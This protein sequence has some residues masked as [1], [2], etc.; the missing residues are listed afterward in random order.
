MYPVWLKINTSKYI[1]STRFQKTIKQNNTM[2]SKQMICLGKREKSRDSEMQ[3]MSDYYQPDLNL[4]VWAAQRGL[5]F[6]EWRVW[7]MLLWLL[8]GAASICSVLQCVAVCCSVL[9]CNV[10]KCVAVCLVLIQGTASIWTTHEW[11]IANMNESRHM[12]MM[13]SGPWLSKAS[14]RSALRSSAL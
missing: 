9:W 14:H 2:K 11:V 6:R 7:A 1:I 8:Q 12:L 3:G 4:P 13:H 10:L 5:A